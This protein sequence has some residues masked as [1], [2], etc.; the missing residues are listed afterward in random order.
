MVAYDTAAEPS[1]TRTISRPASVLTFVCLAQFMVFLGVSSVNLALPSRSSASKTTTPDWGP[2]SSTPVRR[3]G[4]RARPRR[5]RHHRLQRDRFR[6]GRA[7]S[8]PALIQAAHATADHHAFLAA[9]GLGF[10]AL[11]LAAFLMPRGAAAMSSAAG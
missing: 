4:V 8:N 3:K 2:D 10:L 6:A 11:L 7:G 9:A 5:R 1:G